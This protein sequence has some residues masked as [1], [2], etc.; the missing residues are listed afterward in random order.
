MLGLGVSALLAFLFDSSDLF[1]GACIRNQERQFGADG[2]KDQDEELLEQD[3]R[4]EVLAHLAADTGAFC[5]L[6]IYAERSLA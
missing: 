1:L 4:A 3:G 5:L 2:N 6:G